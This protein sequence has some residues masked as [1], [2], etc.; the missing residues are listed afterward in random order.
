MTEGLPS[1]KPYVR[2]LYTCFWIH[3]HTDIR[4]HKIVLVAKGCLGSLA[5][6][7]DDDD[8]AAEDEERTD[9]RIG[10]SLSRQKIQGSFQDIA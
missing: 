3:K 8:A 9:E 1:T 6:A 10:L 4:L 2:V 5:A 7:E